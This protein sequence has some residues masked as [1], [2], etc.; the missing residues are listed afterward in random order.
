MELYTA[1][2]KEKIP[3]TGKELRPQ[4]I[5]QKTRHFG[6]AVLA[7]RGPCMVETTE[8]VDLEDARQGAFIRAEEMLHFLGEFFAE[9]LNETILKQ[10]LWIANFAEH[11][12]KQIDSQKFSVLRKG[13]DLFLQKK[14]GGEAMKLSVSIVT[15]SPISTLF[16]FGV[17]INAAGAPVL[18]AGLKEFSFDIDA[19]A[20]EILAAWKAEF[21]SIEKARCKVLPRV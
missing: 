5:S 8:L 19:F 11:L 16:H 10:R 20:Q 14:E 15:A 17:N 12:R 13:N 3:Y 9:S 2:L 4:W 1:Y 6:D 18:A 21:L 7:F